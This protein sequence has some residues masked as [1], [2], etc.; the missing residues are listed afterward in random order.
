[1]SDII[2]NHVNQFEDLRSFL[3]ADTFIESDLAGSE[4]LLN[5]LRL[6]EP[7]LAARPE[8]VDVPQVAFRLGQHVCFV[9]VD[10]LLRIGREDGVS[11]GEI[12]LAIPNPSLSRLHVEIR[13]QAEGFQLKDLGSRNGTRVNGWDTEAK[14]LVSGDHIQA[15]GMDFFFLADQIPE[16]EVED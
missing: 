16:F 11:V 2:Q 10:G 3:G 15:G 9:P 6:L 5:R 13:E 1:M 8:G 14:W 4:S 12:E 7:M